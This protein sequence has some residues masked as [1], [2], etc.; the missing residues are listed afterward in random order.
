MTLALLLILQDD[1]SRMPL[2]VSTATRS[3]QGVVHLAD[4][5]SVAHLVT[6]FNKD[7]L[8]IEVKQNKVFIKLLKDVEGSID[9]I[10]SS[11]QLYRVY[12]LP[13]EKSVT[14]LTLKARRA[15]SEPPELPAPLL[16]MR[17]MRL[18]QPLEGAVVKRS[19][20]I[21][22]E[23]LTTLVQLQWV[24]SMDEWVG[25]VCTIRN[26]TDRALRLDPSKFRAEG[27][28]VVGVRD[29]KLGPGEVTRLYIV[30]KHD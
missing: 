20:A 23:D 6:A 25:F 5:S 11:G 13:S 30:V 8:S 26:R 16:L 28:Q 10:G 12:V 4:E 29:L 2:Q 24:Y 15:A 7:D 17:A 9:C 22:A 14:Q 3:I 27:V 21:V 18:G 1:V 19:N